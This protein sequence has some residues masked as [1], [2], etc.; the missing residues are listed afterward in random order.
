MTTPNPATGK[1]SLKAYNETAAGPKE[2]GFWNFIH[3]LYRTPQQGRQRMPEKVL[4]QTKTTFSS[5]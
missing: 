3:P 2:L 1:D 4:R 5:R